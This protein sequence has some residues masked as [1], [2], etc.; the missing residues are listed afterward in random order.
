[1]VVVVVV[2]V[3]VV[4]VVMVVVVVVVAVITG[5]STYQVEGT[6]DEQHPGSHVQDSRKG[7]DQPRV[8]P[9]HAAKVVRKPNRNDLWTIKE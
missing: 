7:D 5:Y 2:I 4:V 1:M 6:A 9:S 3:V 8:R